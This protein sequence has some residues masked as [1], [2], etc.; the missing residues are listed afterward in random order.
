M[1]CALQDGA[2]WRC[3]Y[4]EHW[5]SAS[6]AVPFMFTQQLYDIVQI[7]APNFPMESGRRLFLCR[8]EL[9]SLFWCRPVFES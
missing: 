9:L 3:F 7:G 4:V 1:E 8:G 2:A 6:G 5:P